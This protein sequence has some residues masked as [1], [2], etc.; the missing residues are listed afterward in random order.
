M[1][2]YFLHLLTIIDWGSAEIFNSKG[3][4]NVKTDARYKSPELLINFQYYDSSVD[5]W[6]LGCLLVGILFKKEPFFTGWDN[7]D[8]LIK[9]TKVLGTEDL[10]NFLYKYQL[11]L[12]KELDEV[13]TR[14]SYPKQVWTKFLNNDN[15]HLVNHAALYFLSKL[16]RYDFKERIKAKKAL[17]HYYFSSVVCNNVILLIGIKLR[18]CEQLRD[19]TI[20]CQ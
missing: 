18:A 10:F 12:P 17:Q 1:L 2:L 15:K 20:Y 11:K 19:V 9:I 8:L 6:S 16:L 7:Y 5:M 4:Y 14:Q 3:L 13:L